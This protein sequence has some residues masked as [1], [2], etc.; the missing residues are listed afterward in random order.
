MIT[1]DQLQ[2]YDAY[3]VK[4]NIGVL[5]VLALDDSRVEANFTGVRRIYNAELLEAAIIQNLHPL[6]IAHQ[7]IDLT[8][9]E[10]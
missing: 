4:W 8:Q 7:V 6:A 1:P 9:K 5:F 2:R 10:Q 3:F